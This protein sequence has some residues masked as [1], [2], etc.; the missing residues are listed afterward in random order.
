M[1][2]STLNAL[3]ECVYV[4]KLSEDKLKLVKLFV[5]WWKLDSYEKYGTFFQ[6][7]MSRVDINII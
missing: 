3:I 2:R 7:G 5:T 1:D 6:L 4:D